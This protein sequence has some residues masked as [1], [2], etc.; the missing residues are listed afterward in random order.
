MTKES[1]NK[2]ANLTP[3]LNT[4]L[5]GYMLFLKQHSYDVVQG[6][7]K[8]K[9][10]DAQA[11][12]HYKDQALKYPPINSR[13]S[14]SKD[15]YKMIRGVQH[16]L[17]EE[18]KKQYPDRHPPTRLRPNIHP[19]NERQPPNPWQLFVS[20][21]KPPQTHSD[22]QTTQQVFSN[23]LREASKEWQNENSKSRSHYISQISINKSRRVLEQAKATSKKE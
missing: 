7:E 8:W 14:F 20:E 19:R 10:L 18:F 11:K 13:G 21:F 4:K 9:Q 23:H 22:K 17:L 6:G 5:T 16:E 12:Q 3:P 1:I 15:E 2:I